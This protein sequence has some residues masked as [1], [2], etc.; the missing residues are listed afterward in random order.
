MGA[1]PMMKGG[2]VRI[3]VLVDLY[4]G[5]DRVEAF[6]RRVA[7]APEVV[8]VLQL[9]GRTDVLLSVRVDDMDAYVRF[10]DTYL[11]GDATVRA[12]QTLYVLRTVKDGAA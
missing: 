1:E 8:E 2:R 10:A 6:A 4:E 9:S 12:K 3:L 11:N 5:I 7:A